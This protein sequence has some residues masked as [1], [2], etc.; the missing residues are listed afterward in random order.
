MA[1]LN[2]AFQA[3]LYDQNPENMDSPEAGNGDFANPEN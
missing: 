3:I 1:A 2:K